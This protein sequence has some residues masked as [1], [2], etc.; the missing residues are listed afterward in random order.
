MKFFGLLLLL[1]PFNAF[2]LSLVPANV[3]A[4]IVVVV[5]LL[6]LLLLLLFSS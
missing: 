5:A 1:F 6:L 2:L 4:V 3:A